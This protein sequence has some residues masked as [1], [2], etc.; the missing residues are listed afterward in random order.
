MLVHMKKA[1][2]I[3]LDEAVSAHREAER[4]YYADAKTSTSLLSVWEASQWIHN[5]ELNVDWIT[6]KQTSLDECGVYIF[7]DCQHVVHLTE[8][9]KQWNLELRQQAG[10]DTETDTAD[11]ANRASA[12][13]P[14]A[15][16]PAAS[17]D[18]PAAAS[19]SKPRPPP[20]DAAAS[21]RMALPPP[22]P[23]PR[24]SPRLKPV[25]LFPHRPL[26]FVRCRS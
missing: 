12:H 25:R 11:E 8:E 22:P 17:A 10:T 5:R 14:A 4:A 15:D 7:T 6:F 1:A 16:G 9:E 23:R 24:P 3:E 18:R 26:R 20:S 13:R 19:V 21:S 2:S